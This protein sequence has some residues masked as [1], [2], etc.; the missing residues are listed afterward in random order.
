[1]HKALKRLYILLAFLSFFTTLL[2]AQDEPNMLEISET[3]VDVESNAK[4]EGVYIII[5]EVRDDGSLEKYADTRTNKKGFVQSQLYL[6]KEYHIT[7]AKKG[8]LPKTIIMDAR[9]DGANEAVYE[10]LNTLLMTRKI[11]GKQDS[12]AIMGK[13]VVRVFFSNETKNFMFDSIYNANISK[14]IKEIPADIMSKFIAQK[15]ADLAKEDP[16]S[17]YDSTS[18]ANTQELIK[19]QAAEVIKEASERPAS[20][21]TVAVAVVAKID[22]TEYWAKLKAEKDAADAKL[23]AD[24]NAEQERLRKEAEEK[25]K[26]TKDATDAKALADANAEKE[27]LR[28]EAEEKAKLA[29]EA[30]EERLRKEALAKAEADRLRKEAEEKARLA[31]QNTPATPTKTVVTIALVVPA[32]TP[33]V[34]AEP[35]TP[36]LTKEVIEEMK[37]VEDLTKGNDVPER[38]KS[39]ALEN[40]DNKKKA[41]N[42]SSK[43]ET[44]NPLTSLL[45]NIDFYDKS[46]QN[47]VSKQ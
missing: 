19:K 8:Y 12:A 9:M 15:E 35:E 10:F 43:Y 21:P 14:E 38:S 3:V 16:N 29:K 31:K 20:T 46:L 17:V 26:L 5:Y 24:A 25:A 18:V 42:L 6:Q 23:I 22:S 7:F 34:A 11:K 36:V 47:K 4:L 13:P 28:K 40:A 2:K 41:A 33:T 30:D 44:N 1:M 27:R 45:D 32:P 39:F 37:T